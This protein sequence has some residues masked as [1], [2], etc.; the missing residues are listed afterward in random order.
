M[1]VG[2]VDILTLPCTITELDEERN[3]KTER[4]EMRFSPQEKT[5]AIKAAKKR[6]WSLAELVRIAVEDK[7]DAILGVVG[8]VK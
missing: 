5:K 1:S 8:N 4:F 3:M 7:A 6:G 2:H